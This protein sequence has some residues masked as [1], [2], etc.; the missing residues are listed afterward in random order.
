MEGILQKQ[1]LYYVD[2]MSFNESAHFEHNKQSAL[3]VVETA[4]DFLDNCVATFTGRWG[5]I[6]L[7]GY[8]F[9]RVCENTF[10]NFTRNV[11]VQYGSAIASYSVGQHG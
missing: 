1:E 10:M 4:I 5:A 9:I 11:A 8:A 7:W 2:S 6:S 3:S